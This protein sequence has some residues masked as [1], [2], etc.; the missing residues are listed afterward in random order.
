MMGPHKADKITVLSLDPCATNGMIV[1][2]Q[3]REG[4][5]YESE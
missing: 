3:R 1:E 2:V 4:V 5:A